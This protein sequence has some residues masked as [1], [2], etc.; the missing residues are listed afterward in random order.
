VRGDH[1]ELY[2]VTVHKDSCYGVLFRCGV[3]VLLTFLSG[4]R[5]GAEQVVRKSEPLE[6]GKASL[7]LG[8]GR[9]ECSRLAI[10]TCCPVIRIV[11]PTAPQVSE[12]LV[13]LLFHQGPTAFGR[14]TQKVAA[15][16]ETNQNHE[17]QR[18]KQLCG[19]QLF[20]EI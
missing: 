12:M 19:N 6:K 10:H 1:L 11:T 3:F 13:R 15:D 2:R 17:A 18:K 5:F 16:D 7:A 9:R 14:R 8:S 20:H 4:S